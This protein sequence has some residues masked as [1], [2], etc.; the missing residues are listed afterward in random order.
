M[1]WL[2]NTIHVPC[3]LIKPFYHE[4]AQ[5]LYPPHFVCLLFAI[6]VIG[7]KFSTAQ[8][9]YVTSNQTL[10]SGTHYFNGNIH[11][12]NGATL[13][14][15]SGATIQMAAGKK[16]FVRTD[17]VSGN[18]VG[19]NLV[20]QSNS[21]I[22]SEPVTPPASPQAWGGIEVWGQPNYSQLT[23]GGLQRQS[24]LYANGATIENASTA[25]YN[26]NAE[27]DFRGIFSAGGIIQVVETEFINNGLSV[28]MKHY[29]NFSPFNSQVYWNDYSFFNNCSF[30]KNT[31]IFIPYGMDVRLQHVSGVG[32]RGCDFEVEDDPIFESPAIIGIQANN[33]GFILDQL[34]TAAGPISQGSPCPSQDL[35]R[36]TFTRYTYAVQGQGL[37]DF[38]KIRIKN[39]D[40]LEN[41]F[42][43]QLSGYVNTEIVLNNFEITY[44]QNYTNTIQISM[45]G[46]TQFKIE[47]N[48]IEQLQPP[49]SF[50][51]NYGILIDNSGQNYNE[52]YG[53]V[54]KNM[55]YHH[56]ALNIN[57]WVAD[58][59]GSEGLTYLCN[60]NSTDLNNAFNFV[61]A[62]TQGLNQYGVGGNQG[63][64]ST[65]PFGFLESKNTFGSKTLPSA[66]EQHFKN[67][68]AIVLNYY[69]ENTSAETP[70]YYSNILPTLKS[71]E[72][73]C[74]S[75]NL[76]LPKDLFEA[77]LDH[78]TSLFDYI[79]WGYHEYEPETEEYQMY[80]TTYIEYTFWMN[81]YIGQ[82]GSDT[83]VDLSQ[84]AD[85]LA[86]DLY[87]FEN[88]WLYALLDQYGTFSAAYDEILD[89][90]DYSSYAAE[91]EDEGGFIYQ[92]LDIY[93]D[94]KANN[95]EDTALSY[96]LFN[97][98]SNLMANGNYWAR[99]I[100]RYYLASYFD[101]IVPSNYVHYTSYSPRWA[102]EA[103]HQANMVGEVAFKYY[104]NPVQDELTLELPGVA[105]YTL[106]LTDLSGRTIQQWEAMPS[107]SQNLNLVAY[108]AGVYL[109]H[110]NSAEMQN[111]TIK[112]ILQ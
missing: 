49:I 57:R 10:T 18:E 112:L 42:G 35:K 40:F 83:A 97:A 2:S 99:A 17:Y 84:I 87:H 108:P 50:T 46:C 79:S 93:H 13:T 44:N 104:P 77:I 72:I 103:P 82:L 41:R 91:T 37:M 9:V 73:S 32:F 106:T 31:D 102:P 48:T 11:I 63:L 55:G 45:I 71:N 101:S 67:D 94:L 19:S 105:S 59:F 98:V 20:L 30:S 3:L 8:D 7:T 107:G 65:N 64:A 54:V 88:Q 23:T 43:I 56:Q 111:K 62:Q 68:G 1:F 38:R 60:N 89:N 26:Y 53:N 22:T 39:T 24:K 76:S 95:F 28:E 4:K 21:K 47:E 78:R 66:N 52:L 33:A 58:P 90:I 92:Y 85:L 16:I 74:E 86:E 6:A 75:R 27:N 14:I 5:Q 25:I 15:A 81:S 70:V 51:P 96:N 110:L 34:C 80:Q 36:S 100:G 61:V 69:H 29:Q 12:S 109:L